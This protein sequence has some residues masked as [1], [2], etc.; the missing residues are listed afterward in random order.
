MITWLKYKWHLK[1]FELLRLIFFTSIFSI[2]T[3]GNIVFLRHCQMSLYWNKLLQKSRPRIRN[4]MRAA[5]LNIHRVKTFL[6]LTL[7]YMPPV[8]MQRLTFKCTIYAITSETINFLQWF[9]TVDYITPFTSVKST[10]IRI[11]G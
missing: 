6:H 1:Y 5:Y 4:V 2:D 7:I 9:R 10:N 11:A 3:Q 8:E